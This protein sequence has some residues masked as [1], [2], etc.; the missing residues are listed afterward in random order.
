MNKKQFVDFFLNDKKRQVQIE[1]AVA[2]A[3]SNIALC[4][5]WGKRNH[6]LNLPVT[7]SLSISL[8]D[9]GATTFLKAIDAEKDEILLEGQPVPETSS[10]VRRIT[11]FL[12]LFREPR[13][14]FFI[15][16]SSTIPI[17]AGLASSAAGF[18]ALS[19]ALN[20]MFDWNLSEKELSILARL[21]SGSA[22]RSLW[23]GF[24][25]W[26]CGEREDGLDSYA[27]PI[28]QE[29]RELRIG[30]LIKHVEEK[31]IPSREAMKLTQETSPFYAV[32]PAKVDQDMP[33]LKQAIQEKNLIQLGSVAESNAMAMHA[34]MLT[35]KPSI[36]YWQAST[37]ELM[38][39]VWRLRQEGIEVY[40][41][42][43]AGPN[44]KLIFSAKDAPVIQFHFP[45]IQI[46]SPFLHE[47]D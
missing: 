36:L 38:Q 29:W 7:S 5:Y 26:H 33:Q 31:K 12:D 37:V 21:G 16:T 17:A 11:Q 3:P 40:F 43:D 18:A 19:Q 4:K 8:A 23:H 2:Y 28:H 25:E 27:E 24:V 20:V 34:L 47:I 6:E 13:K 42:E 22:S 35:A 45:G 30:L 39:K 9:R 46:V 44:L 10:F 32:W 15:N 41:T 1:N 14:A